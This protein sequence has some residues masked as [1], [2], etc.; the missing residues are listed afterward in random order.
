M[1][2]SKCGYDGGKAEWRYAGNAT[3]SGSSSYRKC[4]GCGHLETCDEILSEIQYKGPEPWGLSN[5]R[6]KVFKGKKKKAV[7]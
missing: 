5:F 7:G 4:P 3:F 2:C 1:R 6:G